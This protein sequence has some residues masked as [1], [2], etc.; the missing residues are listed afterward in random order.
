MTHAEQRAKLVEMMC[1]GFMDAVLD[2]G[3]TVD[4]RVDKVMEAILDTLIGYYTINSLEATEEMVDKAWSAHAADDFK[5]M[6]SAGDLTK[7]E[8]K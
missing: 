3:G 1:D 4:Y 5:A 6:A 8:E 7:P 2:A